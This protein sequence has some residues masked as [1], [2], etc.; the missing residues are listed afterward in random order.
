MGATVTKVVA[1][2][3]TC[4]VCARVCVCVC[5][6]VCLYRRL[7]VPPGLLSVALLF[8]YYTSLGQECLSTEC[9]ILSFPLSLSPP[10][11]LS[12][13]LSLSLAPPSMVGGLTWEKAGGGVSVLLQAAV[14]L[15]LV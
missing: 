11:S 6:C 5:V 8:L 12:L 15:S 7:L 14:F 4:D 3:F 2:P 1:R 9:E 10:L 13:S